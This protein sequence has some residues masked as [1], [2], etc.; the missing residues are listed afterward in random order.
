MNRVRSMVGTRLRA[1]SR[2][3]S[4]REPA[5]SGVRA[6]QR[7]G[8]PGDGDCRRDPRRRHLA[9][10]G[11]PD[12]P[13]GAEGYG[14]AELREQTPDPPAHG[15]S[16][17]A[18]SAAEERFELLTI[19]FRRTEP[20]Q[21]RTNESPR[22]PVRRP[23]LVMPDHD[24]LPLLPRELPDL[25]LVEFGPQGIEPGLA[26]EEGFHEG[27]LVHP[28]LQRTEAIVPAAEEVG[29]RIRPAEP[30][31]TGIEMRDVAESNR[32]L[33]NPHAAVARP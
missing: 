20:G 23:A 25:L 14:T 28:E 31:H 8:R 5:G 26:G 32:A 15:T 18:A 33:E 3:C 16:F 4:F 2:R 13:G 30:E 6:R 19:R 1:A 11:R 10:A 24:A 22:A 27:G 29:R 12:Q 21:C 9:P 7:P 17:Q